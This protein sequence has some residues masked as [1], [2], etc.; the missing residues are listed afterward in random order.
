MVNL[1]ISLS[2]LRGYVLSM[3]VL[4]TSMRTVLVMCRGSNHCE[5]VNSF[6]IVIVLVSFVTKKRTAKRCDRV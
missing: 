1:N 2:V 3:D 4:F 6:R 5:M